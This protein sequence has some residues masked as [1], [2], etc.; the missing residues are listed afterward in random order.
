MFRLKPTFF[1]VCCA[2][3]LYGLFRPQSPP[4]LFEQSDKALHLLAFGALALSSRLAFERLPGWPL[5][6]VLF[7]LAPLLE[8]L[9][10]L[11]QPVRQFSQDDILANA[12]GVLLAWLTWQ[13]LR[14]RLRV[15]G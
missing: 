12:L 9:Q 10:H 11:V 5:W 14:S 3:M 7:A 6:G 8:W 1:V 4:D 13:A 2:L 15:L